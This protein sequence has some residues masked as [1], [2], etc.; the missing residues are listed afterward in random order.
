MT[1]RPLIGAIPR[2]VRTGFDW[3]LFNVLPNPLV[4]TAAFGFKTA[5]LSKLLPRL[6]VVL[7]ML[8]L[9][10]VLLNDALGVVLYEL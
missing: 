6:A 7:L 4:S 5:K 10:E 8:S 2:I 3:P 9:V 1:L